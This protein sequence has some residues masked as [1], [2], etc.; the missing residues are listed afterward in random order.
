MNRIG[1]TLYSVHIPYYILVGSVFNFL[2][3]QCLFERWVTKNFLFLD[4]ACRIQSSKYNIAEK[5]VLQ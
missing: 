4:I 2:V 5:V 3:S 1:L